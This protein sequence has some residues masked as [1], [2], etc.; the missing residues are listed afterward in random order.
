MPGID[1]ILSKVPPVCPK[2]LPLILAILAPHEA[3]KGPKIKETLSP[4]PPVECL[5]IFKPGISLKSQTSPLTL[6]SS[7]K[8]AVSSEF[9]PFMVIAINR[10]LT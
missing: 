8:Y 3:T 5:S 2:P 10:A 6:I 1:S 7:V 9:I 4:T